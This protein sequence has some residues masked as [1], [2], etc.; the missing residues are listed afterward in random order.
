M[1]VLD[2]PPT[3]KVTGNTITITQAGGTHTFLN[4]DR[5]TT[6][7]LLLLDNEDTPNRGKVVV[8]TLE[9][10]H[11]FEHYEAMSCTL[12]ASLLLRYNIEP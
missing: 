9:R 10:E 6:A 4:R 5:L 8:E 7:Y 1:G 12:N 3:T 11:R 2:Q